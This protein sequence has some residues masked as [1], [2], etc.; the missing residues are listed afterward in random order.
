M[1]ATKLPQKRKNKQRNKQETTGNK[2]E[3]NKTKKNNKNKKKQNNNNNNNKKQQQQQQQKKKQTKKR[4]RQKEF[5]KRA[6][7]RASRSHPFCQKQKSDLSKAIRF[8]LD[9]L[10]FSLKCLNLLPPFG[11]LFIKNVQFWVVTVVDRSQ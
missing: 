1:K 10:F 6:I 11:T 7:T 4:Y 9:S 8:Y 2:K 3:T 5:S